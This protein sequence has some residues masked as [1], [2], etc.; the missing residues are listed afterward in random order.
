MAINGCAVLDKKAMVGH[1][2]GRKTFKF[3]FFTYC[4]ERVDREELLR[5]Y[6]RPV[7]CAP[8]PQ[9]IRH[10]NKNGKTRQQWLDP[11]IYNRETCAYKKSGNR[12]RK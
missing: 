2:L 12:I 8:Q 10:Y 7:K 11:E 9:Q 5:K 6:D 4:S 1:L 3:C